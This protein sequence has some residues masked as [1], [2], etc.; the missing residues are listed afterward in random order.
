MAKRWRPWPLLTRIHEDMPDIPPELDLLVLADLHYVGEADHRCP[1]PERNAWFGKELAERAM[2]RAVRQGRPDAIALMG[3]LVDNGLADRAEEDLAAIAQALAQFQIPILVVPGNHDGPVERILGIFGDRLGVHE[4]GGYQ[5][6]TLA[7]A[8]DELDRTAF[9]ESDLA[10]G[11]RATE[12]APGKPVVVLHHDPVHPPIDDAYPYNPTNADAIK[13]RYAEAGVLASIGG[14]FHAGLPPESLGGVTYVTAPALCEAPF[15]FLRIHLRGRTVEVTEQALRCTAAILAAPRTAA[16]PAAPRTAAVPA[17]PRTAAVPAAPPGTAAILAAER[18]AAT[19]TFTPT[20]PRYGPVNIR[21]R[22]KLPHWEME[23]GLYWVTFRLGDSLPRPVLDAILAER[24]NAL[25][26]FQRAGRIPTPCDCQRIEDL[27]NERVEAYLNSGAGACHLADPR[28]ADRVA[29]ALRFFD[30]ARYQLAGWC[31]MPNHVHVLFTALPG[32]ALEQILHSWKSF[33]SK[34]AN[35]ILGRGGNFWARE[36]YDHLVRDD[37][38]L[39]R[40]LGYIV[41]N[42]IKANLRDWQWVW[43]HEMFREADGPSQQ[44][45]GGTERTAAVSAAPGTAAI[46][47]AGLRAEKSQQDAGG[48]AEK[49]QQDAG[50]TAE[51]S[52]QD[53]GGTAEKSQRDAG[54]TKLWD[55]HCHTHYADCRDDVDARGAIERSRAMGLSGLVLAEHSTQLYVGREDFWSARFFDD[56]DLLRRNRHTP[57]CRMDAYLAEILPLRSPSVRLGLEVDSDGRGGVTLLE[58]DAAHWDLLIGAVH[59]VPFFDPAAATAA[60]RAR[61]FLD[62]TESVLRAG[63]DVLAHPFRYFRRNGMERPK[64]L[65]HPLAKLLAETGVAVEINFH[66]NDPD[67]AFFA[68]CIEEGVRIALGTDSHALWEVGELWPHLDVL[69]RAGAP[70]DFGSML[71]TPGVQ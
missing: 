37:E 1:I 12:A 32:Q 17:A 68:I 34:E 39:A 20:N 30:G 26:A 36:Y 18:G 46:L 3:D 19:P 45:A 44:D 21:S 10:L 5:L 2:R 59:W 49:S 56:P 8:Y 9:T 40:I 4:L 25:A 66:T 48:T 50:G 23:G 35:R 33:T 57:V 64:E 62:A 43:I 42:P 60:E 6:I 53:A 70:D 29:N 52:Q 14:H 13:W 58:E 54:G 24:E 28:V 47:A 16:V 61:R 15:R 22:K 65:Y 11:A 41:N 71:F 27:F 7:S 31:V 51:K 69:R 63:V 67:P 55:I 38:E